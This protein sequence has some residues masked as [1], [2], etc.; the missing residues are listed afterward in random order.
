MKVS[1]A[2]LLSPVAIRGKPRL[3][4]ES[5]R[6]KVAMAAKMDAGVLVIVVEEDDVIYIPFSQIQNWRTK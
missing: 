6:E 3:I 1:K 4:I 5:E 2:R